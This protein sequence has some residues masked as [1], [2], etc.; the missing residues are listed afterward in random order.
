MKTNFKE[1]IR[2]LYSNF[3]ERNRLLRLDFK[4]RNRLL[5]LAMT[6]GHRQAQEQ[7]LSKDPHNW[8]PLNYYCYLVGVFAGMLGGFIMVIWTIIIIHWIR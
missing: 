7:E 1:R 3:K 5:R 6:V 2:L 8:T 4:E